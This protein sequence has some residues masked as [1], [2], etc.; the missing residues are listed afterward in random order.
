MNKIILK[1]LISFAVAFVVFLIY[2]GTTDFIVKPK[3]V[4]SEYKIEG[5]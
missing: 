4:E 3:V 2:L 5:N 1:V